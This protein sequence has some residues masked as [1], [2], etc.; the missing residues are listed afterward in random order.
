MTKKILQFLFGVVIPIATLIVTVCQR[1]EEHKASQPVFEITLSKYSSEGSDFRDTESVFIKLCSGTIRERPS[2]KIYTYAMATIKDKSVP[3]HNDTIYIRISDYFGEDDRPTTNLGDTIIYSTNNGNLSKWRD[4][5]SGITENF[6]KYS[7]NIDKIHFFIIEYVDTYGSNHTL[8][9]KN[10]EK[11]DT[12]LQRQIDSLV[13]PKYKNGVYI[14][15][16]IYNII[17]KLYL[18]HRKQG[19]KPT[20]ADL[21]LGPLGRFLRILLTD[22]GAQASIARNVAKRRKNQSALE[23]QH[24]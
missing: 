7:I 19:M 21:S 10:E 24:L 5:T 9:Y 11:C 23:Y 22:S 4:N 16:D 6:Y 2:I 17:E 18:E 15:A 8:C 20:Q 13:L 1:C 14:Y 3:N 12:S